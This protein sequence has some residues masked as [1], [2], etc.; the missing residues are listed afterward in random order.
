VATTE[1]AITVHEG[2]YRFAVN[3]HDYLDTGLF[4]DHRL[5]RTLV[6]RL[7]AGKR[8]LNLFAYTGSAT[9]YAIGGGARETTTVDLSNTYI[10]WALRNFELNDMRAPQHRVVQADCLRFVETHEGRYD[11]VFVDPP[12]FSNSSSMAGHFVVQAHHA[13]LLERITRMLVPKGVVVF[14]TNHRRFRLD[15]AL[16]SLF[17]IEDLGDATRSQDFARRPRMHQCWKLTRRG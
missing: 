1:R 6:G 13:D 4:L 5:T 12:T 10:E 15:A 2:G 7:A 8:F 11:L 14:S 17:E 9:V 3:L 16:A